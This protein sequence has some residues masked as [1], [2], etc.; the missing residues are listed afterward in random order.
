MGPS[1]SGIPLGPTVAQ[2]D[3]QMDQ[4]TA[5]VG[6]SNAAGSGLMKV[7]DARLSSE[8]RWARMESSEDNHII[9]M[10]DTDQLLQLDSANEKAIMAVNVVIIQ[11]QFDNGC[12]RDE[13]V[14]DHQIE[15]KMLDIA[16]ILGITMHDNI[17][18][19]RD[20]IRS[21]VEQEKRT[22]YNVVSKGRR[23]TKGS[24]ELV[25][26]ASSIN[27][28]RPGGEKKIGGHMLKS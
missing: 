27:Y 5:D 28:D 15:E 13:G 17:H 20:C 3:F 24:R 10:G 1:D 22:S 4:S 7:G 14:L 6:F 19:L 26:L 12:S 9:A 2:V 21:L 18:E 23:K 8:G 25:N 16:R 11:P